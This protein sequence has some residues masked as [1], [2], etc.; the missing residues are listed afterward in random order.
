MPCGRLV[1]KLGTNLITGGKASLSRKMMA[2]IAGQVAQL[3]EQGIQVIVVSSGAVAAGKQ[4]LG[5]RKKRGDTSYRQMMA[6]VGQGRLM[7]TYEA[8]FNVHDI[9]IAQALLT[10]PDILNRHGYLNA[11]N[12]LLALLEHNVVPIVNENDVVFVEEL[13]GTTFGDNDNLS[14][15]VANLVDADLLIILS[16]VAGLY[17]ADPSH[18]DKAELI[19]NVECIDRSIEKLAHGATAG[20][21]TGG[22]ITKIE[23]A[24]LATASG[25]SVII[26]SGDEKDIVLR[27]VDGESIGTFFQPVTSKLESRKRWMLSQPTKGQIVIDSGAKTALN[28][29][30]KSLLPAGVTVVDGKFS[31]GDMIAVV[32]SNGVNVANGISNYASAEIGKIKGYRSDKIESILG[33]GF[34]EEVIH[35]DNLIIL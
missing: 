26:A 25:T 6:A 31:R 13:K 5:S 35:R 15:M 30:G 23:A 22:M 20:C 4:K 12:T 24:K 17:T 29:R 10:K 14:A 21:G 16:D 8:F 32:D 2:N 27:L 34:G 18:S 7:Q 11:R 1:V 9:V 3:H 19:P 33:Y 28:K